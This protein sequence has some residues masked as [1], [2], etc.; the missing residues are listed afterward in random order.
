MMTALAVV[1]DALGSGAPLPRDNGELV[2]EEPWQG[3][4][5]GMAVVAVERIGASW[6][7]FRR[8]LVAAIAAR[9]APAGESAA[10][11]YYAAWLDA[12]ETLLAERGLPDAAQ[13]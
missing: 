8:H 6:D 10:S 11:T 12:L 5:L 13:R 1:D 3:R 7:E 9:G 4:A 2:F